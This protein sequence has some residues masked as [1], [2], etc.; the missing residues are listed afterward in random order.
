MPSNVTINSRIN[1]SSPSEICASSEYGVQNQVSVTV[2]VVDKALH[3]HSLQRAAA[4]SSSSAAAEEES[5]TSSR[6]MQQISLSQWQTSCDSRGATMLTRITNSISNPAAT[7][8]PR[9]QRCSQHAPQYPTQ[10]SSRRFACTDRHCPHDDD[11]DDVRAM[12]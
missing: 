11:D 1:K 12:M 6:R 10:P 7:Q 8:K 3:K 2:T 9:L 5:N 4:A